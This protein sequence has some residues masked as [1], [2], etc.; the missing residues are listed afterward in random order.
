MSSL[1]PSNLLLA[2]IAINLATCATF[3]IDKRLAQAGRR[4]I[5]ESTLLALA[6]FGGTLGAY[7]GRKLFRHKTI[8]QPFNRQLF[9]I[10]VAQA[11]GVGVW[12]G[13]ALNL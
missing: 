4:R 9:A 13:L 12:L 1:T 7:A 11:V 2:L 8:K 5:R 10:A 6:M 3:G